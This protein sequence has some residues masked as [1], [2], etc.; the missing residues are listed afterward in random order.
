MTRNRGSIHETKLHSC[1]A[2]IADSARSDGV[3]GG[4]GSSNRAADPGELDKSCAALSI[5][6]MLAQVPRGESRLFERPCADDGEERFFS[7][8]Q[9]YDYPGQIAWHN[10][11]GMENNPWYGARGVPRIPVSSVPTPDVSFK[12]SAKKL[13]DFYSTG[14]HAFFLSERLIALI[15]RLDPGSLERRPVTIR[16]SKGVEVPFFMAMPNRSLSAVDTRRTDVLVMD[17]DYAGEWIRS[18][19]FPNGVSF[20]N[21]DLAGISSF[22]DLDL[23]RW[24]W[25]RELIEAAKAEG[26]KGLRTLSARATTN[27]DVDRL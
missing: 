17:K 19:K 22:T 20:R 3:R 25:S 10:T 9:N 6:E 27:F 14:N 13:V 11:V 4:V 24:F 12:L 8:W 2:V 1:G 7:V 15:D 5:E 21:Q 18:I 23:T 16:A 26:I